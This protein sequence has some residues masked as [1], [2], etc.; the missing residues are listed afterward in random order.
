[1]ARRPRVSP[2][3]TGQLPGEIAGAPV[4]QNVARSPPA[5]AS[6]NTLNQSYISLCMPK[7]GLTCS[8]TPTPAPPG[9]RPRR[10]PIDAPPGSLPSHR[11]LGVH[12]DLAE[13]CHQIALI[14]Q[15][16]VGFEDSRGD[17]GVGELAVDE[18]GPPITESLPT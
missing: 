18:L 11:S 12:Q 10:Q 3:R 15:F 6:I 17:H 4:G 9:R 16:R 5:R 1:M 8:L 2:I 13:S 14:Y 7:V